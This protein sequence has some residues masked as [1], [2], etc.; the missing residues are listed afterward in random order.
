MKGTIL[1]NL[2]SPKDL[3]LS[4]VKS[5]L[6]EF[7]SDDYVLDIPKLIQRILVNFIIVPFRSSKTKKAYESIW[8]DEGSPLII[9]TELIAKKLQKKNRY[10]IRNSN[11]IS[12][13]I[14]KK[15]HIKVTKKRLR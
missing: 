5:Y 10:A 2:G 6:R 12:R 1:I 7:L 9:N 11:A 8:M 4:S 15:I 3:E 13:A 14:N